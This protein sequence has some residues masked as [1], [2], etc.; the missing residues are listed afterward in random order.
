MDARNTSSKLRL[1]GRIDRKTH[2][3]STLRQEYD[4]WDSMSEKE[5][6]SATRSIEPTDTEIV[7]N[8]TT[9]EL[10][11][12]FVANLDPDNTNPEANVSVGWL[13]LGV[14]AATG[15]ATSDTDL[16]S[17]TYEEQ[18]TDVADNGK[19]LLASTF[20]DST[21]GNGDDFDELGLFTENPSDL[22]PPESFLINHATF[23]P[24]TKDNSKTV[25]FDVTLTFSD[26]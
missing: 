11:E 20:L 5:K 22:T 13:G 7:Y 26:V 14:D 15:T 6:L 4:N 23:S 3:V 8:I 19:E 12:Y 17:R 16:N 18:V 25:T 9:D 24:V 10:H 1:K 2:D 21:E